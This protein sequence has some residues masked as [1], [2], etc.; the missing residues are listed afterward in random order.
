MLSLRKIALFL[1][2]LLPSALVLPVGPEVGPV[3]ITIP[4]IVIVLLF[5][6]YVV[7]LLNTITLRIRFQ[8]EMI[9]VFVFV[10]SITF[11]YVLSN[12]YS[13]LGTIGL[14]R[15]YEMFGLFYLVVKICRIIRPNLQFLYGGLKLAAVIGAG[16]S[17]AQYL[18]FA[19]GAF[20][21]NAEFDTI[22]RTTG[23]AH[24]GS[25][26]AILMTGLLLFRM[27]LL[28]NKPMPYSKKMVG[29]ICL[30]LIGVG[31]FLTLTRTWFVAWAIALVFYLI[32]RRSYRT[33]LGI[34]GFLLISG[35]VWTVF[36]NYGAS[37]LY[38][39][40]G[41]VIVSRFT[42]SSFF[43]TANI[44]LV[45]WSAAIHEF[46]KSPIVGVGVSNVFL[47]QM[48]YANYRDKLESDNQWLDTLV[49]QG[50]IGVV[51]L[52]AMMWWLV[53]QNRKA[54]KYVRYRERHLYYFIILIGWLAGS[55]FWSIL[56][57]YI[58]LYFAYICAIGVWLL[59]ET[60][61]DIRSERDHRALQQVS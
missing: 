55:T 59:G 33:I 13:S 54:I 61:M 30:A 45:K 10:L 43:D 7:M 25:F 39:D 11:S 6:V 44:R 51:L 22:T 14:V 34:A 18:G 28:D 52:F 1:L 15:A 60:R 4:D 12:T 58:L 35:L 31:M 27:E 53:S 32:Y 8:V 57:G 16:Y 20:I 41:K 17:I 3:R 24:G 50:V 56:A 42:D 2:F 49:Q 38:G 19:G 47:E 40:Q 5:L 36:A 46:R 37:L 29:R 26:G 48:Y 9:P 21:T 23:L